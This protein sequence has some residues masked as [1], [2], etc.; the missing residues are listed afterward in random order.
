MAV[1]CIEIAEEGGGVVL[2]L[3]LIVGVGPFIIVLIVFID[4]LTKL[5][6]CMLYVVRLV[7]AEGHATSHIIGINP[8]TEVSSRQG[9]VATQATSTFNSTSSFAATRHRHTFSCSATHSKDLRRYVHT[10][11]TV[12]NVIRFVW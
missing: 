9:L 10:V 4:P 7:R 1:A 2:L 3:F 8:R 12:R 11:I 5:L 6:L